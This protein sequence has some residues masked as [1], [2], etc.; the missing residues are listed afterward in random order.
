MYGFVFWGFEMVDIRKLSPDAQKIFKK[1]KPY[2]PPDPWK[3]ACWKDDGSVRHGSAW[4]DLRKASDRKKLEDSL[5]SSI[6]NSVYIDASVHKDKNKCRADGQTGWL[7]DYDDC[8]E[9]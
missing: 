6:G 4:F 8:R 2:F 5:K 3:N 7:D 1:L 9:D